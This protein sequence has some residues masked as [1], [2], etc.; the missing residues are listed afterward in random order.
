MNESNWEYDK[1]RTFVVIPA[2]NE[3]R[4]IQDVLNEVILLGS[5]VVVVDD[6]SSDD[7]YR[8]A[9]ELPVHLLRHPVNLGQGAALATGLQYALSEGAQIIVTFDADGQH[10]AEDIPYL[11]APVAAG[12][13]E[14]AL[15]SRFLSSDFSD[16]PQ[17]AIAAADAERGAGNAQD[18]GNPYTVSVARR[19]L[20]KSAV[21][22]TGMTE[23]IWLSDAHNGF[24]AFSANAARQIK[25]TQNRMAH[26]T[27][28]VSEIA[29]LKLSYIEV[30]VRIRYTQY[31]RLK[32]QRAS[33][34][35]NI[36]I[37][38]LEML[39]TGEEHAR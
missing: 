27:E 38:L 13:V 22:F 31:S 15:G 21:I 2:F 19:I 8:L 24:R 16:R 17:P 5:P 32:G 11:V 6:G 36:I 35:V 23:K 29:R 37:E 26:A 25:L 7:T 34:A 1:R 14:V 33:D 18:S 12:Q 30:P 20:L 4:V 10:L 28:I 3:G 39:F 9:A